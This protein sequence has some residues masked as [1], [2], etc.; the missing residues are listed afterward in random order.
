MRLIYSQDAYSNKHI[1]KSRVRLN[2]MYK[3]GQET[4]TGLPKVFHGNRMTK[5]G[6]CTTNN[7][8]AKFLWS[9][10]FFSFKI[11]VPLKKF[12]LSGTKLNGATEITAH[13]LCMIKKSML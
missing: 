10:N 5:D 8:V 11:Y 6:W 4:K 12:V 2:F 9:I 7:V 3:K 1:R 13:I